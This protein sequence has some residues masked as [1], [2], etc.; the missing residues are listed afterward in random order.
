[1]TKKLELIGAIVAAL[2]AGVGIF[3][4]LAAAHD[5]VELVPVLSARKDIIAPKIL[6]N[7]DVGF[8]KVPRGSLPR[9]AVTA[10]AQVVGRVLLKTLAQNEIILSSDVTR[11][12]DQD[13]E[14]LLVPSGMVGVMV[15]S[16]WLAAPM[17]KVKAHDLVSI[18][19]AV[20]LTKQTSGGVGKIVNAAEVLSVQ[21]EKDGGPQGAL[22]A[23]RSQE[24]E[25]LLQLKATQLQLLL[26]V[27]SANEL[28]T[29]QFFSTSTI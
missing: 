17:P 16:N 6:T 3:I 27:E 4:W 22:L 29:P 21:G 15:P 12:R 20:P 11:G 24:A 18:F 5:G 1:M 2:L 10:S 14:A 23:L 7:D 26:V 19:V 13:S 8:I 9:G 25:R 28:A